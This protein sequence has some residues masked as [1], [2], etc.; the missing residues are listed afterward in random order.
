MKS[1]QFIG[2]ALLN[3]GLIEEDFEFWWEP[4]RW[5][6]RFQIEWL[7]IKDIPF[8]QFDSLKRLLSFICPFN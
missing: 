5:K 3:S 1:G 7:Y 2:V 6:Q 4:G 8:S